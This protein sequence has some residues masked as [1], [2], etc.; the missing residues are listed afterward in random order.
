[1][2]K[3]QPKPR[4]SK[5]A[6]KKSGARQGASKAGSGARAG[7]G[8]GEAA[9]MDAPVI[10]GKAEEK[11]VRKKSTNPFEF[12]QQVRAEGTKVTWTGRNETL[13][14]TAMVLVM[15]VLMVIFF[16]LV[17]QTLRFGICSI[18]PIE[19]VPLSN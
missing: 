16:F 8:S 10:E 2:K 17:D 1:M 3:N 14:S 11:G 6:A 18:L 5:K 19:C 13:I 4:K 7:T 9:A 12:I 15:V